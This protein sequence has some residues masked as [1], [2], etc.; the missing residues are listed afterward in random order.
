MN[1]GEK[2]RAIRKKKGLTQKELGQM[3][4]I[5]QSAVG[6][7]ENSKSNF[8]IGTIKKFSK[9]LDVDQAELFGDDELKNIRSSTIK[10][11]ESAEQLQESIQSF[12]MDSFMHLD[13]YGIDSLENFVRRE[14]FRCIKQKVGGFT[15]QE[16]I[17]EFIW[18]YF[19]FLHN[20]DDN[21][22][23][24][25]SCASPKVQTAIENLPQQSI[26]ISLRNDLYQKLLKDGESNNGDDSE[27]GK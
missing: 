2:I 8:N 26:E 22:D 7:I 12:W 17:D 6:Q 1:S 5:S 3:L 18:K 20:D 27:T 19:D 23:D 9:V 4:G 14:L 16:K 13:D 10:L 25:V 24:I 21:N 15:T 11:K